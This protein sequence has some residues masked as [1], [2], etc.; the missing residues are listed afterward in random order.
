MNPRASSAA[1]DL[2]TVLIVMLAAVMMLI[3]FG[4]LTLMVGGLIHNAVESVTITLEPSSWYA[5]GMLLVFTTVAAVVG[6]AFWI[7]LGGKPL[8]GDEALSS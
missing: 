4:L 2:T 1:L 7:S 8:F 5:G 6:Y 3:R